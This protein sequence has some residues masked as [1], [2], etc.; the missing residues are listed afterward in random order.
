MIILDLDN[1]TTWDKIYDEF[2]RNDPYWSTIKSAI[3]K[4]SDDEFNKIIQGLENSI[5][6][7]ESKELISLGQR[8]TDNFKKNYT[9]V[10]AYHACRTMSLDSFLRNGIIKANTNNLI[11]EAKIYFNDSDAVEEIINKMK[12][13][14]YGEEYFEHGRDKIG[15]FI[16][17]DGS[18]KDS[19][20]LEY[21][22][23]LFQCIANRLGDGAIQK[24]SNQG[25]PTLIQCSLPI[26]WLNEFTTFPMMHN[27]ALAPLEQL[28]L[29]L[30]KPKE[31]FSILGA[32]MLKR[33]V[34]KEF[35]IETID[36]TSLLKDNENI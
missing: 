24:M 22:S 7:V 13:E 12:T 16:S 35:I 30:R 15:F 36:M 27:Y 4:E 19:H 11:E 17:R 29:R 28:I 8:C 2:I 3:S 5:E 23:E 20:Y 21:G 33:S 34:P 31:R 1:I 25:T 32:F 10:A 18:L 6:Y 26:I 9:H 14:H